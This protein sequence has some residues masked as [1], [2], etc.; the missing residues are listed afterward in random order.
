MA[1]SRQW[2]LLEILNETENFFS[3]NGIEEAR[4]QAELLLADVLG[5]NRLDLYL[6]FERILTNNEV[7]LYR[8][9]VRKRAGRMPVQYVLGKTSFRHID[10]LVTPEVLIPRY[11]TEVLVEV[12]LDC[13]G[14][15]SSGVLRCLDLC[16]GSGAIALSIAHE[17][18]HAFVVGSDV[19][20][21]ALKIARK[22]SNR[23][24]LNDKVWWVC[25]DL[26]RGLN[27]FGFDVITCNPPYVPQKEIQS[28][29]PE[30]RDYE[31]HLALDGGK[32]GLDYYRRI[33]K[34]ATNCLTVGGSLILE[35]GDG[36][37]DEVGMLID[38]CGYF[39]CLN[40]VS[41]LNDRPRIVTGN[42]K[43]QENS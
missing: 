20:S 16:C 38:S 28:L 37:A 30:I 18:E 29:Q 42:K 24:Q 13:A 14:K 4:L 6:Q 1:D 15:T 10:L 36:Q 9:Y 21:N 35:V 41:D 8:E 2:Q 26:C 43:S 7:D 31:P 19:S 27:S 12:A 40:T 32:D 11:E 3:K 22:N 5:L 33:V 39:E 34:E 25:T 17:C 23:N